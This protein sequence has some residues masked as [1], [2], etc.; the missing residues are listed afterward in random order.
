MSLIKLLKVI[1]QAT[2]NLVFINDWT[3]AP[4]ARKESFFSVGT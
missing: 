4:N 3:E 1:I 2:S